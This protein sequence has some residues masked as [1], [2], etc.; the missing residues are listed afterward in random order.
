[1]PPAPPVACRLLFQQ[2]KTG[3]RR[4]DLLR[5][6]A[7]H[8]GLMD[9]VQEQHSIWKR[10]KKAQVQRASQAFGFVNEAD[11][12]KAKLQELKSKKAHAQ[13]KASKVEIAAAMQ[14]R[15]GKHRRLFRRPPQESEK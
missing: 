8:K 6:P 14:Q 9:W 7:Q 4:M 12:I 15:K 11:D 13:A 3:Q 2:S 10:G 1:M 5:C